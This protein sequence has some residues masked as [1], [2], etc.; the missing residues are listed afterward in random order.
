MQWHT[1]ALTQAF[2]LFSPS[3]LLQPIELTDGTIAINVRNQ[4]R[5]HCQCRIVVHSYDGGLTLPLEGLIFDEALV[6]PVV[7]AGA[8]QKEGVIYFTNPCNEE[9]SEKR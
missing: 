2:S 6:D 1:Q 5:Y 4:N 8:L 9:K 7:A 3:L